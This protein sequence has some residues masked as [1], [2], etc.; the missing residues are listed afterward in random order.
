MSADVVV[1]PTV[2]QKSQFPSLWQDKIQVIFDGIDLNQFR[3]SPVLERG[4]LVL[5]S[6]DLS[7]P[8]RVPADAKLM[9]YATRG[10][11]PLRGFPKFFR[12]AVAAMQR[13][14][15]LHIV[16]AGSDR[17]AYSYPHHPSQAGNCP[18]EEKMAYRSLGVAFFR[19]SYLWRA[20]KPLGAPICIVIS[21]GLMSS[22]GVFPSGGM[23]SQAA[24][25]SIRGFVRSVPRSQLNCVTD[26]DNQNINCAVF[27]CLMHQD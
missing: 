4:E 13:D 18:L 17:A 22:V 8:V 3:P 12:A 16:I 7:S 5:T 9:T 23:W 2:W 20:A 26:L 1:S 25:E 24:S 10:M 21:Q 6:G 15:E 19:N 14:P 11:E 27:D